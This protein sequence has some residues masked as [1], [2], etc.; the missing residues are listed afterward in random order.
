MA[1]DDKI[2]MKYGS[3][4]QKKSLK[5][6]V[7][8]DKTM[9]EVEWRKQAVDGWNALLKHAE[10]GMSSYA[11]D[12]AMV[13]AVLGENCFDSYKEYKNAQ[14]QYPQYG[15]KHL[16]NA[17]ISLNKSVVKDMTKIAST[18][19]EKGID[20]VRV[21]MVKTASVSKRFMKGSDVANMIDKLASSYVS[22]KNEVVRFKKIAK[23][24]KQVDKVAVAEVKSFFVK[25]ASLRRAI[26]KVVND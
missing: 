26:K 14:M 5:S 4:N 25:N 18:I 3:I 15:F 13:I 2:I 11:P 24:V 19:Q 6:K 9:S 23:Q 21:K 12:D 16:A 17:M 7:A 1:Y 20:G 10:Y 22:D 8:Y